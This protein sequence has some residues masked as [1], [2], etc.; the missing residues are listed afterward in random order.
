[1]KADLRKEHFKLGSDKINLVTTNMDLAMTNKEEDFD[2][3]NDEK[4]KN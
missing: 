4:K 3:R 1:L 2:F